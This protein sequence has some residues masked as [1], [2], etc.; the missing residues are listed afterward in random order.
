MVCCF[1]LT[2]LHLMYTSS[3]MDPDYNVR[4]LAT[5]VQFDIRYYFTRR[6]KENMELMTKDWFSMMTNPKTGLKYIVKVVDEET[7]NH[8]DLDQEVTS[9]MMPEMPGNKMC[10][11]KSYI[12]YFTALHLKSD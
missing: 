6:G 3:F 7:K 10:P 8:K 5:K 4:S 1:L 11:V 2:D 12:K 9:A